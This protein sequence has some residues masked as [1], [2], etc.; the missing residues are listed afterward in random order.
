MNLKFHELAL[1]EY[2]EHLAYYYQ[3]DPELADRL[4]SETERMVALVLSNPGM[5]RKRKKGYHRANFRQFSYYLVY[6]VRDETIHLVSISH[7]SRR[8]EYWLDR[9]TDLQ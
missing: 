7:G 4:Q 2:D 6:L 9:L 5:F 3:I 8:P 1:K